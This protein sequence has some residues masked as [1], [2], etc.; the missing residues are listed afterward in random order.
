MKIGYSLAA[1]IIDRLEEFGI[2]SPFAGTTPRKILISEEEYLQRVKLKDDE[3]QFWPQQFGDARI[4]Y[5]LEVADRMDGHSFEYW[6]ANLLRKNWFLDVQV[7]RG[8]GDHGVDIVAIKDGIKY[9]IQCKCYS[10]PLGNTPVQEVNTGKLMYDCHVGVVMTNSSF[11]SGAI[12]L[13]DKAGVLLW[14]RRKLEE[15]L[16]KIFS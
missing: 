6:C 13:A 10:S 8:S 16:A 4:E 9:A 2:I 15:M 5:E 1:K 11:T 14:D 3:T 12:E 7:T